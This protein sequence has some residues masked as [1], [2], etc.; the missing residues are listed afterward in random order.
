MSDVLIF[1]H[2]ELDHSTLILVEI[3]LDRLSIF[4]GQLSSVLNQHRELTLLTIWATIDRDEDL[5]LIFQTQSVEDAHILSKT[6]T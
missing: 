2:V 1:R 6:D 5:L 4:D 3:Q